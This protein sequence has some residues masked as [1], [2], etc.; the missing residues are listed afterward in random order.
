[1]KHTTSHIENANLNLQPA[2]LLRAFIILALGA[3][4]IFSNANYANAAPTF[5]CKKTYSKAERTICNNAELGKLDRWMAKEYKFLHSSMNRKDRRD[6][7][8]DQRKWI[9]VRNRCGSRSTCIMD[10]YY[11]RISELVEW[12]MP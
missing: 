10:Q 5:S 11:F 12:N 2:R 6:L 4:L 9:K 1:M 3:M 8:T 7:K